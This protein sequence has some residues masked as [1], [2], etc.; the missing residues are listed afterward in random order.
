LSVLY[1]EISGRL[2]TISNKEMN[3]EDKI[4]VLKQAKEKEEMAVK[5]IEEF[6]SVFEK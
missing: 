1:R 6:L 5:K 4:P 2:F 3:A